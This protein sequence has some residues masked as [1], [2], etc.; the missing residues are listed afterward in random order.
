MCF[1]P[2]LSKKEARSNM[3]DFCEICCRASHSLLWKQ[4]VV[5]EE[6][7]LMPFNCSN[8]LL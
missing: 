5:S 2:L 7:H 1:L 4:N 8:V 3:G 6:S